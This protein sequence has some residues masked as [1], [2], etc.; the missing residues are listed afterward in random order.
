MKKV[1][2][3]FIAKIFILAVVLIATLSA[4]SLEDFIVDFSD[5]NSVNGTIDSQGVT[6]HF[7]DVGQG[8]AIFV[9]LPEY[10]SMLI[11]AGVNGNGDFIKSYI[12]SRGY[13]KIDYLVA[14]HPHSDHIG[15]MNY[16]VSNMD[17]G[18]I[19]MPNVAAATKTYERLLET[20]QKKELKIKSARAGMKIIDSDDLSVSIIAPTEIDEDNF[21]NC[22]VVI[23]ITYLKDSYLFT[24]DAEKEELNSVSADM[25]ADVLKVGHHGS[26]SSSSDAFLQAVSP[27]YA[28]ISCG[29]D[30]SYGHPHKETIS[31]LNDMGIDYYRT[32]IN[33]TVT[34]SCNGNDV[35]DIE[36][37]NE[38]DN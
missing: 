5:E 34:I 21:N 38:L 27:K 22:S 17:I 33:G 29:E 6:V 9:E 10:K 31:R 37:E 7:L 32:D 19:Y 18:Q 4:C 15:S 3:N 14:T 20:I 30:N 11:D 25:S 35:F 12:N 26:S 8:D 28:V 24:G 16:I 13:N 1:K 23:K 2:C 36:C